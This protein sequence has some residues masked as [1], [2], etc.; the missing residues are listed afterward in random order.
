MIKQIQRIHE[1]PVGNLALSVA[2]TAALLAAIIFC[3]PRL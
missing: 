1:H 2:L 3:L